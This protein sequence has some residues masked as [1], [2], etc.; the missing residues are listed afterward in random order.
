[1]RAI[2]LF[3]TV[4]AA[5][6]ATG[7][8][9]GGLL[10]EWASWRWV[11]FVN[12]PI[13]LAV[14]VVGRLVLGETERRRGRFDL[15]G[16]RHL[17]GRHDRRGA[18]AGRG[19]HVRLERA[20]SPWRPW[21]A[22]VAAAGAVRAASSRAPTSRSCPCASWPARTRAAANVARGLGYAGMYG[23]V[24]FL[25]QFL[26]DV[27]GHSALVTGL[28]LPAHADHRCSCPPS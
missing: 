16:A 10:T 26:Q 22:G 25:T 6:G 3:T 24:F 18:R 20:R 15:A 2:G 23:M 27:Q 19:G 5:G 8:V 12:V 9:A 14:L 17:H 7:L 13:G 1:M 11:M 28:G 4:S 21:S